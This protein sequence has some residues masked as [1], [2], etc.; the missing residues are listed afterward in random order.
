MA[1]VAKVAEKRHGRFDAVHYRLSGPYTD[2]NCDETVF[3][4][5]GEVLPERPR[6]WEAWVH[7]NFGLIE[8]VYARIY[9]PD[10]G[11]YEIG[12]RNLPEFGMKINLSTAWYGEE[13]IHGEYEIIEVKTGREFFHL[14]VK[15]AGPADET[16][17]LHRLYKV[18]G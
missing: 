13:R 9:F 11:E 12:M 14:S 6:R 2:G 1:Q 18:Q 17:F 8:L 4:K 5:P 3:A 16:K 7:E 15:P 10:G